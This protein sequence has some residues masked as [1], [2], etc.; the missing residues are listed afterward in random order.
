MNEDKI[1][2]REIELRKK[3]ERLAGPKGLRRF[4]FKD[5]FRRI[6]GFSTPIFGLSW[7]PGDYE[8]EKVKKLLIFLENRSVLYAPYNYE[9]PTYCAKSV[10]EIRKELTTFLAHYQ[11]NKELEN[12]VRSFR[13]ASILFCNVIGHPNYSTLHGVVQKSILREQLADLRKKAGLAIG[14]LAVSYG[15]DVD[16]NLATIIPYKPWL[17]WEEVSPRSR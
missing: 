13:Q 12:L 2:D 4:S 7:T 8:S 14:A 15:Y 1:D 10:I 11:D 9:N 16:E 3:R 5:I 17:E 6:N